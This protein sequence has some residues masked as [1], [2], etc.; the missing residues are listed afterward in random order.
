MDNYYQLVYK[1][2]FVYESIFFVVD[3]AGFPV[4]IAVLFG[5]GLIA[6]K[7]IVTIFG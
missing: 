4:E 3:F 5:P 6:W 7:V 1:Q 2:T